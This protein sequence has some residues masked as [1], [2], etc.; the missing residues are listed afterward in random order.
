MSYLCSI[1]RNNRKNKLTDLKFSSL[2]KFKLNRNCD[3]PSKKVK[4]IV[5]KSKQIT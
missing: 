4:T 1:G 2:W 3:D 5:F